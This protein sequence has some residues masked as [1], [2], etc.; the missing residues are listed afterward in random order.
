MNFKI[1]SLAGF[2]LILTMPAFASNHSRF[3]DQEEK[4]NI[5]QRTEPNLR[6][7]LFDIQYFLCLTNFLESQERMTFLKEIFTKNNPTLT[8][9][10]DTDESMPFDKVSSDDKS[11]SQEQESDD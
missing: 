2:S 1:L 4:R 6:T 5:T 8:V 11:E 10:I 9:T 7:H 3:D